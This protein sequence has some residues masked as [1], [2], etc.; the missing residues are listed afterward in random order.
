MTF[1]R[2]N[3]QFGEDKFKF[4]KLDEDPYLEVIPDSELKFWQRKGAQ[5]TRGIPESL[6]LEKST[7]LKHVQKMAYLMDACFSRIGI[8][9]G[10]GGLLGVLPVIGDYLVLLINLYILRK[11]TALDDF[12]QRIKTEM[13]LNLLLDF[14]VGLIPWVGA[15]FTVAYRADTRNFKLARDYMAKKYH[16]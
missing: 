6:P 12:P 1:A 7:K 5:R 15:L 11:T 9:V 3:R 8:R 2:I 10:L 13:M 16:E 14:G 4:G